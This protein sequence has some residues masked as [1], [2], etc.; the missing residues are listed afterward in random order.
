MN[1]QIQYR[2]SGWEVKVFL[3]VGNLFTYLLGFQA[4]SWRRF[5]RPGI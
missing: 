1:E 5:R 2:S 3:K 4:K